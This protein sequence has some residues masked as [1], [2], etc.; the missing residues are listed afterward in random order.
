MAQVTITHFTRAIQNNLFQGYEWLMN[1]ISHDEFVNGKTVEIPIAGTAPTPTEDRS[2]YPITVEE[3]T[4]T[5]RTYDLIKFDAGAILV[6]EDDKRTLSYNKA[7]SI[8]TEHIQ[9]INERIGLRGLY[10]WSPDES[11]RIFETTGSAIASNPAATLTT[12]KAIKIKDITK[13]AAKLVADKAWRNGKMYALMPGDMYYSMLADNT[14]LLN[15]NYMETSNLPSGVVSRIMG[16]NI[17]LTP[18]T[19]IYNSS[20]VRKA[21]GA[22][23]DATD[24]WSSLFWCSDFVAKALGSIKV[25]ENRDDATYQGDIYSAYVR[26]NATQLRNSGV[27]TAVLVQGS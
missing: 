25:F 15:E 8:L 23:V 13:V 19:T 18:E 14:E 17:M 24:N 6:P 22:T 4:D 27:G 10:N 2:S 11:A 3:R 16:F 1:S 5:K 26:A 9:V 7:Q 12:R 20:N 21:V